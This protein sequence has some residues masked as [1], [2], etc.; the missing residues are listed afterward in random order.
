M[1]VPTHRR[2]DGTLPVITV[3]L[4]GYD[5]TH[6]KKFKCS[7]CGNTV[8]GYYDSLRFV[9]PVDMR[10]NPNAEGE[11][12]RSVPK[13]LDEVKCTNRYRT[14]EGRLVR[15]RTIYLIAR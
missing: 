3:G 4:D 5:T 8:F 2:T 1:V 7:V 11:L 6:L 12:F 13:P 10:N 9:L 14:E 15:C